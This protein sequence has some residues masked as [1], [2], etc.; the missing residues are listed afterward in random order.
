MIQ[1]NLST[2]IRNPDAFLLPKGGIMRNLKFY[3]ELPTMECIAGDTLP[4]FSVAVNTTGASGETVTADVSGC[5]MKLIVA[6]ENEPQTAVLTKDCTYENGCFTV[7]LDSTD[8]SGLCRGYVFTMAL[9]CE[10]SLVYRKIMGHLYVHPSAAAAAASGSGSVSAADVSQFTLHIEN[11]VIH[12]TAEEREVWNGKAD[13][14]TVSG[15]EDRL[16]QLEAG[17]ILVNATTEEEFLAAIAYA[18]KYAGI[19]L[20]IRLASGL[21]ATLPADIYF[22]SNEVYIIGTQDGGANTNEIRFAQASTTANLHVRNGSL[23]LQYLDIYGNQ[24]K[25]TNGYGV[26]RSENGSVIRCTGCAFY[27]DE[28]SY[29]FGFCLEAY[30]AGAYLSSCTLNS[31]AAS[32]TAGAL[33][34]DVGGRITSNGCTNGTDDGACTNIAQLL[35]GGEYNQITTGTPQSVYRATGGGTVYYING[36]VQE[37]V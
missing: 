13:A 3:T 29:D 6:S 19:H 36:A 4:L 34:S 28:R 31:Y 33:R 15:M 2:S 23:F 16:A 18:Q 26:L 7:K 10:N 24:S 25:K 27:K 35:T 14:A 11:D 30:F 17:Q 1:Q 37:G 12:I 9:Y 32:S 8:T 22:D 20:E 21:C 5:T